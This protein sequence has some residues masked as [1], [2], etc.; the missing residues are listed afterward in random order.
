MLRRAGLAL[1]L[2]LF[3]QQASAQFS[4]QTM[5]GVWEGSLP[6]VGVTPDGTREGVG[7]GDITRLR[8]EVLPDD[9]MSV[10]SPDYPQLVTTRAFRLVNSAT[11]FAVVETSDHAE[12]W[13][14]T[15]VV[16]DRSTILAALSRGVRQTRTSG[17][18]D[19]FTVGA[20]GQLR[21]VDDN[22]PR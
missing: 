21:K 12:H 15:I 1:G 5:N 10:S 4:A 14:L 9:R 19:V 22:S 3:A 6:I 20:L 8:V 7:I 16:H 18:T 13:A 11:I 2:V 17:S